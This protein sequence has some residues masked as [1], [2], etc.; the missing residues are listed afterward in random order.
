MPCALEGINGAGLKKG[1][2][3]GRSGCRLQLAPNSLKANRC[4]QAKSDGSLFRPWF[5]AGVSGKTHVGEE[6]GWASPLHSSVETGVLADGWQRGAVSWTSQWLLP[7]S[8][9]ALLLS[10]QLWW[11]WLLA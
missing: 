5:L 11:S 2:G 7:F 8:A 3:G 10:Y 9:V 4:K 1:G 6:P